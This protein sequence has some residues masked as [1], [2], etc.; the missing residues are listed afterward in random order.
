MMTGCGSADFTSVSI[1]YPVNSTGQTERHAITSNLIVADTRQDK[2]LDHLVKTP[3]VSQVR[4][5]IVQELRSAGCA[6]VMDGSRARYSLQVNIEQLNYEIPGYA[7][8]TAMNG[9]LSMATNHL[10]EF[11]TRG[12]A[13]QIMAHARLQAILSQSSNRVVWCETFSGQHTSTASMQTAKSHAVES[14]VLSRALEE[15][16]AKLKTRLFYLPA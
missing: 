14:S 6:I 3:V 4:E 16:I 1:E 12:A 2:S 15:A 5:Q 11:F 7:T 13:I 8:R 9:A 10:S